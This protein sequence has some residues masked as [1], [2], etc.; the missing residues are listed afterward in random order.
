[1]LSVVRFGSIRAVRQGFET[2]QQIYLF[3]TLMVMLGSFFDEDPQLPWVQNQL[4]EMASF[5]PF[6]RIMALHDRAMDYL[7]R[8]AGTEN[9]HLIKALLRFRDFDLA[10]FDTCPAQDFSAQL[11]STLNRLFPEKAALQGEQSLIDL[12]ATAQLSAADHFIETQSGIGLFAGL[13]F[14]LGSGFEKDPRF[15]W[16]AKTFDEKRDSSGIVNELHRQ[17]MA[18]LQHSLTSQPVPTH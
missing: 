13:M 15:P 6:P 3:L 7:D 9:Q 8:L 5:A 14:M 11:V 4:V 2:E 10:D 12:F 18:F 1:M 16:V 17:A